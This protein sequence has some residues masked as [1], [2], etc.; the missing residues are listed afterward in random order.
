[1]SA[2]TFDTFSA[3]RALEAAGV[4]NATKP[5]PSLAQSLHKP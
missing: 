4:S 2:G 3:A 5:K 1:M